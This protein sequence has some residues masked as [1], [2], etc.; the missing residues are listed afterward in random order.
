MTERLVIIGFGPVAASLVEGLLPAVS[1]GKLAL[2]VLGAEEHAAY[3]RV[4]LAEVAIGAAR[5]EHLS[6][7]DAQRMRDAGV[8]LRLGTAAT[9]VDRARRVVHTPSG[10][11]PYDRLVFATGARPVIPTVAGLNFNPHAD[12]ALPDGVLALRTL[13]D[14]LALHRLLDR[15]GRV[16]VLG[17]GILGLEAALGMAAAGYKPVLVH[18]G[19]SPLARVVDRDAGE[20]LVRQLRAA[21][22][23]VFSGV[24]ATGIK[25]NDGRFCALSTD[26][27]GEIQADAL[28]LSTGVRARTELAEGCGLAAGSGISVN[29]LLMADASGRIFAVGDCAEVSGRSPAGLLAPGWAQAS[30]LAAYLLDHPA[31]HPSEPAPTFDSLKGPRV[32]NGQ[33]LMLKGQGLEL[34]A[35]GS[36]Q[37]GLFDDPEQQVMLYADPAAGR[38]LKVVSRRGV[39]TGFLALGLPRIGAE[40]ALIFERGAQLPS[41]ISLLLRL[42]APYDQAQESAGGPEDQL[43]RCSGATYGQVLQAVGAGCSTVEQ[44]GANCRAG[45]GCGGCRERIEEL[46]ALPTSV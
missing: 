10:S 15:G 32:P 20:L 16:L 4:L 17:G 12:C 13:D 37:A 8:D 18:H 26:T 6:M 46:L 43:C 36:V 45:T 22:V 35:A 29:D 23:S 41:D 28:L 38:Y 24:R 27:H 33:I 14:A 39:A 5:P 31:P 2:T 21:G 19:S 11:V 1:A 34:T 9:G 44:V 3:N 7:A 40:L 42:D 30:W 25:K